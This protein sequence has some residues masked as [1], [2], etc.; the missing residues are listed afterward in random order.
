MDNTVYRNYRYH[1]IP[2]LMRHVSP[3][4]TELA[5]AENNP[6]TPSLAI[7]VVRSLEFLTPKGARAKL[8]YPNLFDAPSTSIADVRAWLKNISDSDWNAI[9]SQE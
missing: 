9:I 1:T 5:A 7:D 4:P 6:A 3:T 2:S 8:T